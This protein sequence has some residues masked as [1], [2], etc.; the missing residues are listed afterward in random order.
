MSSSKSPLMSRRSR[1]RSVEVPLNPS[2]TGIF[3]LAE[4]PHERQR[5]SYVGET[6][7][8]CPSPKIVPVNPNA[9]PL[10]T[11]GLVSVKLVSESGSDED[12]SMI[13]GLKVLPLNSE[14]K[15]EFSLKL[16]KNSRRKFRLKFTITVQG[17]G[18]THTEHIFSL[19]FSV[20]TTKKSK[21]RVPEVVHMHLR[22]GLS[23]RENEV[24]IKGKNFSARNTMEVLFG[25]R[26]ANILETD[27]NLIICL[28][29]VMPLEP[30]K[31][32]QVEVKVSNVD[33]REGR[34]EAEHN[35][36]FTY[37]GPMPTGIPLPIS[38]SNSFSLSN[39]LT[40]SNPL[41]TS[42]PLNMSNP[43][44][45]S[46]PTSLPALLLTPNTL[47]MSGNLS[48]S[49]PLQPI[50]EEDSMQYQ[51]NWNSEANSFFNHYHT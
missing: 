4:E 2:R 15:A 34:L 27:E 41:V 47:S 31:E 42:N 23:D 22:Y 30:G 8:M 38:N 13:E 20:I 40:M 28:S 33:P 16:V 36:I 21:I 1:V 49:G 14:K 9:L 12:D 17:G 50:K 26:P 3:K 24:W 32:K 51:Y 29:P 7:F 18:I 39:S 44:S 11:E 6:R 35:L 10:N 45:M 25:D 48:M 37:C 5:K 19:P 46:G 43:L